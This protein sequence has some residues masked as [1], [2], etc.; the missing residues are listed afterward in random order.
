MMNLR[1]IT[2]KFLWVEDPYKPP[3][4]VWI[5][6]PSNIGS[7]KSKIIQIGGL[8]SL[9]VHERGLTPAGCCTK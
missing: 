3:I 6:N 4:F 1:F 5:Y 8:V 2:F 7:E 9:Y